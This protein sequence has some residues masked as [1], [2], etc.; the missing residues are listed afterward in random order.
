MYSY[1]FIRD[2]NKQIDEFVEKNK[3]KKR[4]LFPHNIFKFCDDASYIRSF[5]LFVSRI[6]YV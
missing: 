5:Y 1:I 6:V 2:R 3:K 4:Y